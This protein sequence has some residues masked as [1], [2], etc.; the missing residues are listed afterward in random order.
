MGLPGAEAQPRGQTHFA[1]GSW[2]RTRCPGAVP[3][4]AAQ[5][6]LWG[7]W[8]EAGCSWGSG[9]AVMGGGEAPGKSWLPPISEPGCGSGQTL[10]GWGRENGRE[11]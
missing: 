11:N 2:G 9:V 7:E 5:A 6:E 3:G 8:A 10:V 1:E 4:R